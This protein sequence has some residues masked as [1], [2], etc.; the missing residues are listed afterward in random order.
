MADASGDVVGGTADI[1]IDN[2]IVGLIA[3]N[4]EAEVSPGINLLGGVGYQFDISKG[5]AELMGEDVG[6]NELK[7]FFIRAGLAIDF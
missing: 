4:L 6:E 7:A 3:A 1:E 5:D 2:S